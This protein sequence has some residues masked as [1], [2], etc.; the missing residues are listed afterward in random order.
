MHIFLIFRKFNGDNSNKS[1]EVR[2]GLNGTW[3]TKSSKCI[4]INK[5]PAQRPRVAQSSLTLFSYNYQAKQVHKLFTSTSDAWFFSTRQDLLAPPND[6]WW[7]PTEF[8]LR[9]P[10]PPPSPLPHHVSQSCSQAGLAQSSALRDVHPTMSEPRM[11][12]QSS[13]FF[14]LTPQEHV[15]ECTVEITSTVDE[16]TLLEN[17]FAGIKFS[18]TL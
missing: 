17:F 8:A 13:C 9:G 1:I 12:F 4:N 3:I 2:H 5:T 7:N 18:S 11:N 16:G 10:A 14:T 6:L 15:C